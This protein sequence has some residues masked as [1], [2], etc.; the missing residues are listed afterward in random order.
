MTFEAA[1][2]GYVIAPSILSADFARLGQ[3]VTDVLHAGA[4][5]VH[6]DVMDGHFVPNIT[7]GP[8]I[9]QAL[10]PVTSAVLDVHLM[11]DAPER[12]IEAF[13]RAGSDIITV[14]VEA[15]VH[16][17]R[18]LQLIRSFGKKTGVS[19]NPATSLST[20]DHV[21]DDIDM[22]LIMSV[23][24]GFGGQSYIDSATRKIADLRAMCRARG[25]NTVIEVDGGIKTDNI[26]QVAAA[27]A[28]AFVAGSAIYGQKDYAEVIAAMRG[29]LAS[30]P[31]PN[32]R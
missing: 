8:L 28:N 12:Y 13:A 10:R 7:I 32:A 9:V 31:H 15:T 29:Q 18:T 17:H 27:G 24:P 14:H 11:I 1:N 4:D 22:V 23:N 26:A 3:E 19:L 16:L 20:L 25:L 21:L 2:T 6:V 30:V 5:W